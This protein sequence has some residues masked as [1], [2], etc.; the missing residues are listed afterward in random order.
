MKRLAPPGRSVRLVSDPT[1]ARTDRFGRVLAYVDARGVDLG[2][3]MIAAGWAKT[4]V[5]G[6]PFARVATYRK[7]QASATAAKRGVQRVCG[8]DYHRAR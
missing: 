1:Q 8:G 2:R 4:Y 5:Y 6:R 7:A 3:A